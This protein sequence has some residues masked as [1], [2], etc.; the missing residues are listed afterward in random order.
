MNE[1]ETRERTGSEPEQSDLHANHVGNKAEPPLENLGVLDYRRPPSSPLTPTIDRGSSIGKGIGA[2][3]FCMIAAVI[4]QSVTRDGYLR[5]FTLTLWLGAAGAAAYAGVDWSRKRH[6]GFFMGLVL[7]V[8]TVIGVAGL[9][10]AVVC[11]R[12]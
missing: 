1:D 9:T 6:A 3:W 5:G 12:R 8:L 11:G 10:L 4:L 2:V 7:G